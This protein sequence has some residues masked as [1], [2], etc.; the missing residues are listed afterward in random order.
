MFAV[1]V[2]ECELCKT[3]P[4]RDGGRLCE[5]CMGISSDDPRTE[6]KECKVCHQLYWVDRRVISASE[7]DKA[8]K[9]WCSSCISKDMLRHKQKP[10]TKPEQRKPA[11]QPEEPLK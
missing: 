9:G 6:L 3:R 1:T 5:E 10:Q 7:I 8:R 2:Q 11:P 4:A